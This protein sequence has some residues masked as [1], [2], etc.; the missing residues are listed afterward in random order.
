MSTDALRYQSGFGN[1]YA[2]EA[3]PGALPQ[4]RTARSARPSTSTPS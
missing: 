4:G 1:E 3:V 2:T